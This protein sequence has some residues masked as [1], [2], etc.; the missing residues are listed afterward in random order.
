MD[1]KLVL[2]EALGDDEEV[3]LPDGVIE[4]SAG[5]FRN[6]MHL[7]RI[8]I[9]DTCRTIGEAAFRDCSALEEIALPDSVTT[10]GNYCFKGCKSLERVRLSEK[11]NA[12]PLEAFAG[13]ASLQQVEGGSKI[14][15]IEREGFG[16]CGELR[17]FAGRPLKK[18]AN[19]AFN[20]CAKL[21]SIDFGPVLLT[22]GE[23]AFRN[24][25]S[26][27][28][29]EFPEHVSGLKDNAFADCADFPISDGEIV[30]KFP[31][32][33]KRETAEAHGVLRPIDK[34]TL[35]K[36]F[37]E[38]HKD[39][40]AELEQRREEIQKRYAQL[41]QELPS[42][43]VLDLKK[44]DAIYEKMDDIES[45]LEDIA[46]L[47]GELNNPSWQTLEEEFLR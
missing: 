15:R 12:I 47:L 31:N 38:L 10:I 14:E 30:R 5:A 20:N 16:D 40:R 28:G 39:D 37:Q 3:V 2:R 34:L 17:S 25:A 45:E 44:R 13:C 23:K 9:P 26:F 43:G 19:L 6:R 32:A 29:A 1:Y 11:M 22:V 8:V 35:A 18:I 21:E 41:E 42:Y 4:I 24:C 27:K 36:E 33:F 7:R 46:A